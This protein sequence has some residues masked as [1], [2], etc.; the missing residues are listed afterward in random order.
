VEETRECGEN[1]PLNK[2]V[3]IIINVIIIKLRLIYKGDFV[4]VF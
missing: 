2:D 1:H 3:S 4:G